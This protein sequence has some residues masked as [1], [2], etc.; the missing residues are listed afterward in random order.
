MRVVIFT[1]VCIKNRIVL[2]QRCGLYD[3]GVKYIV[4]QQLFLMG[5][6]LRKQCCITS[7]LIE[8]SKL[9]AFYRGNP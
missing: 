5:T 8:F 4:I 9:P 7:S 1:V 3:D 6:I 2:K